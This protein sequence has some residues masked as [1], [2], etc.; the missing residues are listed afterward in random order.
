MDL[1][2]LSVTGLKTRMMSWARIKEL[3]SKLDGVADE[4]AV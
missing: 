3:E 1:R 2:D 4:E